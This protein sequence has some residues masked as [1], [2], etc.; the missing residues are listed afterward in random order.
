MNQEAM[1]TY[2]S[3]MNFS[4][5]EDCSIDNGDVYLTMSQCL[6][7]I[8]AS[9]MA[10][11]SPY[12]LRLATTAEDVNSICRLV[13]GLAI[14]EKEP[15]SVNIGSKEY[16]VDG[17]FKQQGGG[18]DNNDGKVEPLFYCILLDHHDPDS[19]ETT[20]CGMAFI[21]FGYALSADDNGGNF[22]YL[23]DL[24]I[25][26]NYRKGGAGTL[27]MKSLAFISL[28]LDS[29]KMCWVA[30]DWNTPALNFYYKIGAIVE[31]EIK[32]TRYANESLHKFVSSPIAFD[33]P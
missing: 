11:K 24:F 2:T 28:K 32:L 10:T 23:E 18:N 12:T 31:Q 16:T 21:Y 25:E 15:D 9:S 17:G 22:L 1:K 5:E 19:H 8:N 20:T 27:V 13:K 26:E 7:L 6:D 29:K 3:G 30:L 33:S 4:T 14:Y